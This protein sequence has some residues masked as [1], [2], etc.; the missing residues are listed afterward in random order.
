MNPFERLLPGTLTSKTAK[1]LLSAL[2]MYKVFVRGSIAK[3]FVVEP[4]GEF[5]YNA[6][7]KVSITF[8]VGTSITETVLSF[9]LHT[10]NSFPF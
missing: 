2:A 7:S 10:Y 4:E 5:A 1:Q 8:F 6:A 3:P 9:A